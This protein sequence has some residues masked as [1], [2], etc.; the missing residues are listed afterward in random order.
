MLHTRVHGYPASTRVAGS[1]SGT[2]VPVP[3]TSH[4]GV[5]G[6]HGVGSDDDR[7]FTQQLTREALSK[8]VAVYCEPPPHINAFP[9]ATNNK[10]V[11]ILLGRNKV[12]KRQ[13]RS[14]LHQAAF[15]WIITINR[16][17]SHLLFI[18]LGE[19]ILFITMPPKTTKYCAEEI[20]TVMH[21]VSVT[22]L[23][24]VES[25]IYLSLRDVD[26]RLWNVSFHWNCT[27]VCSHLVD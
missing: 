20:N 12:N 27:V 2:R 3:S 24:V 15:P 16:I 6:I 10:Y 25:N 9:I 22:F 23:S 26:S 18:D 14:A 17:S 5:P 11:W 13:I 21:V 7:C 8:V 19:C 1:D 4:T